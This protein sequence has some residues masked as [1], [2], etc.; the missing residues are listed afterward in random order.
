MTSTESAD[1]SEVSTPDRWTASTVYADMWVDP[2]DDPRDSGVELRDERATLIEYLRA[3]RLTLEMKCADLDAD[4]LARRSVPP[5]T[6]SLLGLLRH[7]AAVEHNWFRRVMSG[8]NSSPRP[9]AA[10]ND[11]DADW[12]GAIADPDVVE[13]AWAT[14]RREVAFAED[15]VASTPDLGTLGRIPS[16]TSLQL[17]EVLVHMIEEYA[18]HCGHADLL[19]ECIDGRVGQ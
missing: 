2:D 1:S 6:M 9:Y 12:N 13:D 5:S 19:R 15:F 14:W 17:R 8:E 7:M 18:R 4:Q 11:R 16:G 3:Y 10:D